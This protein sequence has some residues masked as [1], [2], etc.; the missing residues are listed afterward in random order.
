LQFKINVNHKSLKLWKKFE[1]TEEHFSYMH[2]N[3][4]IRLSI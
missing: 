1:T 2:N 4:E 3:N